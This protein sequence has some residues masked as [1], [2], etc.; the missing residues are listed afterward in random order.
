MK[1]LGDWIQ[2]SR[3]LWPCNRDVNTEFS[4][5]QQ[6]EI[7][8]TTTSIGYKSLKI[9]KILWIF[10]ENSTVYTKDSEWF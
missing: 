5:K 8:D 3:C 1:I 2:R 4:A 7:E 6:I 9:L 10:R